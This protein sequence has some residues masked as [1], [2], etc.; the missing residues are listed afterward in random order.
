MSPLRVTLRAAGCKQ[1][2]RPAAQNQ[3]TAPTVI[4]FW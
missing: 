2:R 3:P 4:V 1:F